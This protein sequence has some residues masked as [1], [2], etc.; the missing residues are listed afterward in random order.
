MQLCQLQEGYLKYERQIK[1][2]TREPLIRSDQTYVLCN[3]P[4]KEPN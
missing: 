1:Q 2:L 4:L 3:E